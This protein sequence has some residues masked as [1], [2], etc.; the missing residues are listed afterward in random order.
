MQGLTIA[1]GGA[2]VKADGPSSAMGPSGTAAD[3]DA[4]W[5]QSLP[6]RLMK[7]ADAWQEPA[8]WT[9]MTRVGGQDLPGE[10][11]GIVAFG[12]LSVHGWDLARATQLPFEPD[13]EGVGPLF[14]LI[15]QTFGSGQDA[16]A[17]RLSPPLSLSRL[18]LRCSTRCSFYW[19]GV[20]SGLRS[21]GRSRLSNHIDVVM[22]W[23]TKPGAQ[24]LGDLDQVFS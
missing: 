11:A 21:S 24:A 14:A 18:T 23:T 20:R 3:L 12:E 9:G 7:L 16:P 1:F 6:V 2:A 5:R 8:A 22:R 10:V 4:D 19:A 15:Q 13:P 17:E